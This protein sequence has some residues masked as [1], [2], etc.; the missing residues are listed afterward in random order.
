MRTKT[1]LDDRLMA[2]AGPVADRLGFEIVRI[3]VMGGKRMRAQIMAERPDGTMS[4]DDCAALSRG[5][6]EVLE[7]EDP[8]AGEYDL[9]VSSPGID[10]PLTAP[11]HFE[12]WAGFTAKLELDRLVEGRKRFTGVLAGL[13]KDDVLLNI[14]GEDETALIP[15]SWIADAKLVMTDE[16][17]KAD[18]QAREGAP[19]EQGSSSTP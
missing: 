14:K 11:A 15:F 8:I 1:P 9:E 10:R 16:L 3:R 6:S 12:R 13:E 5:L 7:A 19:D 17:M 18:L 4:V 2:L